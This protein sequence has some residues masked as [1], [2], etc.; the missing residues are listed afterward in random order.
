MTA[1]I[2]T[3]ATALAQLS[4][5]IALHIHFVL[6]VLSLTVC[7]GLSV[8]AVWLHKTLKINRLEL[9]LA[10]AILRYDYKQ[11]IAKKKEENKNV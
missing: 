3:I 4:P 1:L 6:H 8:L 5:W 7:G 9:R 10:R 11:L 2:I